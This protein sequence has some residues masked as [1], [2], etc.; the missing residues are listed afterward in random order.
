MKIVLSHS[1]RLA[2]YMV[3][4]GS[5]SYIFLKNGFDP[6]VQEDVEVE[7]TQEQLDCVAQ[8]AV[9]CVS[10]DHLSWLGACKFAKHLADA[11]VVERIKD[12]RVAEYVSSEMSRWMDCFVSVSNVLARVSVKT[13]E[14]A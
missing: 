6:A 1:E 12:K 3:S 5:T 4:S 11:P 9:N 14:V 2:F 7:L 8:D 13:E 10:I